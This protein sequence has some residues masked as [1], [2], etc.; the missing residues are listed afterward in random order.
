[1]AL[2]VEIGRQTPVQI[3]PCRPFS[4]SGDPGDGVGW[5]CNGLSCALGS[6]LQCGTRLSI[7]SSHTLALGTVDGGEP[8]VFRRKIAG[9]PPST[10]SGSSCGGARVSPNGS[11]ESPNSQLHFDM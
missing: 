6:G 11:L 7:I 2:G 10:L 1:M 9:D 4:L 5:S 8:S 3:G